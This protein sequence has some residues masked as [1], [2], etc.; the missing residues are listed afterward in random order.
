METCKRGH[1]LNERNRIERWVTH[2]NGRRYIR[3]ECR[4]CRNALE[5]VRRHRLGDFTRWV[6]RPDPGTVSREEELAALI[7]QQA[8]DMRTRTIRPQVIRGRPVYS[9]DALAGRVSDRGERHMSLI[10][11]FEAWSIWDEQTIT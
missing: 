6:K 4:M 7:E 10:E 1:L 2:R 3:R 5:H 8:R 11:A 9:L